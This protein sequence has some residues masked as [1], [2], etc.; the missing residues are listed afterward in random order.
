M[1]KINR[2][3]KRKFSRTGSVGWRFRTKNSKISSNRVFAKSTSKIKNKKHSKP[4]YHLT[5]I[6]TMYQKRIRNKD[7][8]LDVEALTIGLLKRRRLECREIRSNSK[9]QDNSK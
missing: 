6:M 7:L 5:L 4:L 9:K 1:S 3:A 2:T 8:H